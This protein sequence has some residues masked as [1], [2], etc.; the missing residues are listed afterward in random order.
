MDLR[1]GLIIS[2]A[3]EDEEYKELQRSRYYK[4]FKDIQ[5]ASL[6]NRRKG[7]RFDKIQRLELKILLN[8][9][10]DEHQTIR[11]ALK[12]PWTTFWRLR[13]KSTE[14]HSRRRAIRYNTSLKTTLNLEQKTYFRR[15]MQPPTF[16]IT[17]NEI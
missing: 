7:A 2:E 5:S 16:L 12:I 14:D 9:Y 1:E 10:P 13:R 3:G 11:K 15:L 4:L 6:K 8:K 17:V